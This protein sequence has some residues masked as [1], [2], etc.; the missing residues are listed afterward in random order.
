M[1]RIAGFSAAVGLALFVMLGVFL[2]VG[3]QQTTVADYERVSGDDEVFLSQGYER[4]RSTS[5]PSLLASTM[6]T[7]HTVQLP[8][9]MRNYF[10][11]GTSPFGVVIY[12]GL[13]PA[14]DL[15]LMRDAGAT[16][17]STSIYW[18]IIEPSK[19]VYDWTYFDKKA[20]S[21]QEAGMNLFVLFTSNPNWAAALPG[22]PVTNTQDLVDFTTVMVERYDCDGLDDAPG[23]PCIHHWSFYAEPDNGWL[24]EEG[25]QKGYW[26]HNGAGYAAMLAQVA[27]AMHAAS[28]DAHVMIGGLA[29]DWFEEDGGPYV[30]SFLGDTLD[31]LNALGGAAL[32]I[33][34]VAFHYYP[35]SEVRWPSIR[36]KI[37]EIQGIMSS[38]GAGDIP[39]ICPEMG[40]WSSPL[41]DSSEQR[42]AQRLVQMF[43][44]GLSVDV[45]MLSWYK[46]PDAAVA[47][48]ADDLYPDR[49]SGLVRVDGSLKPSYYAY[50]TMTRELKGLHYQ[51]LFQPTG[52]EGYVFAS[53][54]GAEKTV[55][56]SKVG[57]A[58]AVFPVTHLRLVTIDG[59]VFDVY[60]NQSGT[61]GDVDRGVP[62][63]IAIEVYENVPYFVEAE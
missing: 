2:I 35:I 46:I 48:S 47:G 63:Q 13:N 3:E 43:V 25:S 60:D 32:Y 28:P 30:Q 22:G 58:E 57:V 26:G 50:Q 4:K 59:Q 5:E 41:F 34:D 37:I 40:Y 56:W 7:T 27:P 8:L 39:L 54:S 38:H 24:P 55:L 17:V 61:P 45:S 31:A 19:G 33:D 14:T 36:E 10:S 1:L 62:G 6:Q 11:P 9:A 44:R 16:W 23:Q 21:A 42:Q 53:P 15:P 49:T 20:Q 51:R 29:Y 12:S 18:S 52:V